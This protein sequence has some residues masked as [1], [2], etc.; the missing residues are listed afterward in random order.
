M[1]SELNVSIKSADS[2]NGLQLRDRA[3]VLWGYAFGMLS[4]FEKSKRTK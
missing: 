1:N 2:E 3:L 4:F